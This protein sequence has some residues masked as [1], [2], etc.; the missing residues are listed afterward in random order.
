[1]MLDSIKAEQ[2]DASTAAVQQA[3]KE[4]RVAARRVIAKMAR[5]ASDAD[6]KTLASAADYQGMLA[7]LALAQ[8][9]LAYP[10]ATIGLCAEDGAP[11]H[12]EGRED[13]LYVCCATCCASLTPHPGWKIDC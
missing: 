11:L 4:V 5:I 8:V 10:Q 3:E 1:M 12:F 7:K 9:A 13:G 2:V 6:E